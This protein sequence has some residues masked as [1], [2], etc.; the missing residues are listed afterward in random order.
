MASKKPKTKTAA[1]KPAGR[2]TPA[3]KSVAAGLPPPAPGAAAAAKAKFV[4][5]LVSRGEAVPAG[6]PLPA[7][8]THEIVGKG[9]DGAPVLKRKRFSMK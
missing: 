7:G 9:A 1:A 5:G 2:K 8:A 6:Q 3:A 4:E